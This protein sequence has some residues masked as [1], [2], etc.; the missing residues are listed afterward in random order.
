MNAIAQTGLAY[1]AVLLFLTDELEMLRPASL[2]VFRHSGE[3]RN[4]VCPDT[5]FTTFFHPA[6]AGHRR[7]A[8]DPNPETK[9]VTS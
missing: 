3:S 2:R 7:I 4:L 6:H 8:T 1:E 5:C 9:H